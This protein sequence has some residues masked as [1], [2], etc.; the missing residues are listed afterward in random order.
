MVNVR[1]LPAGSPAE[2]M[3]AG[4]AGQM[5]DV[6]FSIFHL[7]FSVCHSMSPHFHRLKFNFHN[8]DGSWI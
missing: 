3:K 7:P 6:E 4:K 1:C 5:A 8:G 2:R